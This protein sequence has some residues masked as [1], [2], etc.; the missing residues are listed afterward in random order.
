MDFQKIIETLP[1]SVKDK[2]D[3]LKGLR[4]RPDFHPEE[5]AFE[6]VKI[7][8]ERLISIRDLT[9]IACGIFHDICKVDT[10]KINEKTG[11]PTSPGHEISAVKFIESDLEVQR[12][13]LEFG[14][15]LE[16]VKGIC[17]NHMRIHQLPQMREEKRKKYISQWELD[18]IL[19]K[20]LIFSKADDMLIEFNP[21]K[22]KL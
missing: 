4:E 2:L 19:G 20:L 17:L 13:I 21:S 12:W 10:V 1:Q 3:D 18:G 14:A 5:S 7:V 8:T 16:K 15:D 11:F 9:L 6:H 22:M